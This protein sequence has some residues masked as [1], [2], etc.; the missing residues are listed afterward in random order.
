MILFILWD[1]DSD[2]LKKGG[3]VNVSD[4]L[5]VDDKTCLTASLVPRRPGAP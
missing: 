5:R 3:F 4:V 2:L 1:P